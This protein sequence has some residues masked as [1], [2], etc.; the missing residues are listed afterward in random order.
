MKREILAQIASSAPLNRK[1]AAMHYFNN[2]FIE[3]KNPNFGVLKHIDREPSRFAQFRPISLSNK[4]ISKILAIRLNSLLPKLLSD[5][6][7]MS[8]RFALN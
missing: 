7:L 8:G 6:Q 5:S 1:E 3:K 4:I 2:L